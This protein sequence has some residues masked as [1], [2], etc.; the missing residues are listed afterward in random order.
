MSIVLASHDLNIRGA[1]SLVT[2]VISVYLSYV[3][4]SEYGVTKSPIFPIIGKR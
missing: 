2:M 1:S 4:P 3:L